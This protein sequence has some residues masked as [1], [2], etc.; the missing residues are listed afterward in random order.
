MNDCV[1]GSPVRQHYTDIRSILSNP[2][3][4]KEK[5]ETYLKNLISHA[6]HH[7]PYYK[8]YKGK[9]IRDFPV[10]N[11]SI[12]IE[13]YELIKISPENIPDQKGPIR[14]QSTSG[15]TGTPFAIPQDT[16]KRN[17]RVAELK[18]FG[19]LVG[20]KS[21]DKLIHLRA[22]NRW[23][24]KSK[25][26]SLRENIIPFNIDKIDNKRLQELCNIINKN[27]VV[28]LRGYAS[29]LD[30]LAQYAVEHNIKLPSLKIMIAGSESLQEST[31]EIVTDH[32]NC[33]IISQYANEENGILAQEDVTNNPSPFIL[34]HASYFF[35]ILKLDEDTPARYGE[36]GRIILTDLFN[37]AFPMI[38][39]DTGD[40]GIMQIDT[41]QDKNF[42]TLIKLYGRRVDLVFNTDGDIIHPTA[43]SR[44]LKH[45]L[46]IT[47]WQFIQEAERSYTLKL[48][49]QDKKLEINAIKKDLLAILGKDAII[50]VERAIEITILASGKRKPIINNW[51]K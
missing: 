41:K 4:G 50:N 48:V 42:F 30:L 38:R 20:F 43:I 9:S 8:Q 25:I 24:T 47:Q 5:K 40:T 29:S 16:R 7:S 51:K 27:D 34:N 46:Q 35:E 31:R 39:Y 45:Y 6:T 14:I 33:N 28:A 26:Q 44:M 10:V 22:W 18:Y 2:I 36:L 37:Y 23:Q 49:T 1:K 19:A 17:R 13:N 3:K 21:H 12:L 15:S 11:K 32:L